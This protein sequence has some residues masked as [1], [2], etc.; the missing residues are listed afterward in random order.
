VDVPFN[1]YPDV[2][3]KVTVETGVGT[4]DIMCGPADQYAE[5]FN[6][7]AVAVRS[8]GPVPTPPTDALSNMKVLDALF[9]SAESGNWA[10][11]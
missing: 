8:S 6:A 2:P 4:R 5:M 10:E 3:L 1:A 11:V 7:F 9:A